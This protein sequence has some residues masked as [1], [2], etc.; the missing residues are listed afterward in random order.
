MGVSNV[1]PA[2]KNVFYKALKSVTLTDISHFLYAENSIKDNQIQKR[3]I[4]TFLTPLPNA[5]NTVTLPSAE[6]VSFSYYPL[7]GIKSQTN[8]HGKSAFYR[9]DAFD[10][11]NM[12]KDNSQAMDKKSRIQLS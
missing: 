7:V 9:Y 11:L 4:D 8:L 2:Y 6:L 10:R 12:I 5:I 1:I 3:V